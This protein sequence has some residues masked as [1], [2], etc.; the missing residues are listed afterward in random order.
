[1]EVGLVGI[2]DFGR[3]SGLSPRALRLYDEMGLLRPER[4]DA[5]SGY[6]WYGPGQVRRARLIV[7]L[8][9]LGVPL[10]EAGAIVDQDAGA[11]AERVA[12]YWARAEFE[13][14]GRRVLAGYLVEEL[15]GRPGPRFE[16]RVR[17]V[18]ERRLVT[19]QRHV[20]PDE[21]VP[22]GRD[23]LIGRMQA[24][25]V[26]RATGTADA[27]FLIYHGLVTA[28]SDGPVEWCRPLDDADADAVAAMHPD[29]VARVDPAHEEAYVGRPSA[30]SDPESWLVME[31]LAA[32]AVEHGRTAAG[33]IRMSIVPTA[34]PGTGPAGDIAI[35]L[36]A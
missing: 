13:H 15:R 3:L 18:P 26:R 17:A 6:R 32:W 19:L 11:A 23:F 16:V 34:E 20:T 27:P 5:H 24:A 25:G 7:A 35:P 2:G 9:Q 8:R 22:V 33:P 14:H 30:Q 36:A 28:D 4:V 12:D 29:L 1:M 31:A 21:L 10:A